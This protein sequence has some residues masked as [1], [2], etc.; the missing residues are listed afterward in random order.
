MALPAGPGRGRPRT[1][2]H[3]RVC[4]ELPPGSTAHGTK[5]LGGETPTF[6]GLV[7]WIDVVS[8][9]TWCSESGTRTGLL[10][11]RTPGG[12][13][14]PRASREPVHV[15][16]R[17][18]NGVF[19][20]TELVR[21]A[22]FCMGQQGIVRR[23][24][25]SGLS[26]KPVCFRGGFLPRKTPREMR[27]VTWLGPGVPFQRWGLVRCGC[28]SPPTRGWFARALPPSAR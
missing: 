2:T 17:E 10:L 8:P 6:V 12:W 26:S 23:A 4:F 15:R 7:R 5:W 20:A 13:H 3:G 19:K 11:P 27:L 25:S 18:Q 9:P 16:Y 1:F 28:G 22:R 14:V 24:L 21:R